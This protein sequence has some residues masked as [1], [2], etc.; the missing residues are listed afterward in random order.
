[1]KGTLVLGL[2]L[3]GISLFCGNIGIAIGVGSIYTPINQVARPI[4]CGKQ[5]LEIV[6]HRYSYRPGETTW[7]IDAY[8]IDDETG[9]KVERT[10]LVHLVSGM[11]YGLVLFVFFG[12]LWLLTGVLQR[13]RGEKPG[14]AASEQVKFNFDQ[15]EPA[16]AAPSVAAGSVDEKLRKLKQLREANLITEQDFEKKKSEILDNL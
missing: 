7:S 5:R 13:L 1:M 14:L 2:I 9:A 10:A 16:A 3:L 15:P 12:F 11:F 4:V 6:Q 8:C